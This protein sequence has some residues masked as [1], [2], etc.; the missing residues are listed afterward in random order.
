M[1]VA[2]AG[3]PQRRA[4]ARSGAVF[5]IGGLHLAFAILTILN[6]LHYAVPVESDVIEKAVTNALWIP[7]HLITMVLMW[8]SLF[9][10]NIKGICR[11]LSLSFAVMS[12]WSSLSLLWALLVPISV[13]LAGPILGLAIATITQLLALS[14]TGDA[15]GTGE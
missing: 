11:S 14:F 5:V 7:L 12:V 1:S 2:A 10:G 3:N 15:D 8:S 6:R 9:T 13:S 4:L